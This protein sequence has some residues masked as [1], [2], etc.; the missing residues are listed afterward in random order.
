MFASLSLSRQAVLIAILAYGSFSHADVI[1]KFL[2]REYS[3]STCLTVTALIGLM[4]SVP[5]VTITRGWAKLRGRHLQLHLAR[6]CVIALSSFMAVTSIKLLP[7]PEFYSIVFLSPIFL[8]M[9]FTL[10]GREKL[11]RHRLVAVILSFVGVLIIVGP[12]Y[13]DLGIGL[14]TAFVCVLCSTMGVLLAKKIGHHD[15][16]PVYSFFPFLL[17]LFVNAPFAEWDMILP[18]PKD[19]D[20]LKFLALGLFILVGHIGVPVAYAKAPETSLVAPV[21]YTQMLWAI[22]YGVIFFDRL[23][24]WMTFAGATLIIS[25]GLYMLLRERRIRR[26]PM[27][28]IP[29]EVE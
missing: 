25:G 13:Q 28:D 10:T 29:I 15:P 17:I 19:Y 11:Y 27:R 12:Q 20:P 26:S 18:I 7:L 3:P 9:F 22:I 4:I 6:G 14:V 24:T 21:F 8:M 23:P 5:W 2:T 1:T 16:L